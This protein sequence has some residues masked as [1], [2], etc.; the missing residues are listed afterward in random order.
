MEFKQTRVSDII[1]SERHMVLSAPERFGYF[2][3][4][5][6]GTSYLLGH[7]IGG[8]PHHRSLI[9]RWLSQLKNTICWRFS[10]SSGCTKSRD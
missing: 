5:A 7:G 3:D 10:L 6:M 9:A 8:M 1:E 4:N 2:H